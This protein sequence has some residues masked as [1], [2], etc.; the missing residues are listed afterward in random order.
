MFYLQHRP[1]GEATQSSRI[2][3]VTLIESTAVYVH[4]AMNMS[5]VPES[6]AKLVVVHVWLPLP[7]SPQPGQPLRISD[8]KLTPLSS[9]ADGTTLASPQQLQQKVPQLDLSGTRRP[10]RLVGPVGEQHG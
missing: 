8:D 10:G 7:L 9:P 1:E 2:T 5:A 6:P 4:V 3:H